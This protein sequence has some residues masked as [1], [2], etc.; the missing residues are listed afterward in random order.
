MVRTGIMHKF[1]TFWSPLEKMHSKY[2]FFKDLEFFSGKVPT[3]SLLWEIQKALGS[4]SSSR[5][6]FAS[7][8]L[9]AKQPS[10]PTLQYS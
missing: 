2:F 7:I 4:L 8:S 3:G 1:D 10:P 9:P 6:Y 5:P